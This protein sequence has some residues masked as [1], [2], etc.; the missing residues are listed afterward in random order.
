[1]QWIQVL[2]NLLQI[3]CKP[4]GLPVSKPHIY[5]FRGK[6]YAVIPKEMSTSRHVW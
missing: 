4:A 2:P 1:M 6:V 3:Q 5:N